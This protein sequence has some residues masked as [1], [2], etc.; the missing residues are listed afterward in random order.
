M[1]C[2]VVKK[3]KINRRIHLTVIE[4]ADVHTFLLRVSKLPITDPR[5]ED[6]NELLHC[7]YNI[8]E[9]KTRHFV[10]NKHT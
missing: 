3:T 4:K 2:F 8:S 7:N 9:R 1:L 10:L 5:V 6:E